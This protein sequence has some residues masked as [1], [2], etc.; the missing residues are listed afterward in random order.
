MKNGNITFILAKEVCLQTP[1]GVQ[2]TLFGLEK[3]NSAARTGSAALN[4]V[5]RAE[6]DQS[7]FFGKGA[8]K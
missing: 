7:R 6:P 4:W 2:L 8:K 1:V 5:S 3:V